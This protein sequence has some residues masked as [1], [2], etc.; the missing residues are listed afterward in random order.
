[1]Y[2][3]KVRFL[4]FQLAFYRPAIVFWVRDPPQVEQPFLESDPRPLQA[5]TQGPGCDLHVT[6]LPLCFIY[7]L[8]A[9]TIFIRIY[10][11]FYWLSVLLSF[12]LI[13]HITFNVKFPYGDYWSSILLLQGRQMFLNAYRNPV[14]TSWFQIQN[15]L[16]EPN[17]VV[18]LQPELG[19][20]ITNVITFLL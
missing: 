15:F 9:F 4:H 11:D 14:N 19:W 12:F 13:M 1:M 18:T 20:K 6:E 5:G 3:L 7:F 2:L 8:L 10:Q 17:H 16:R